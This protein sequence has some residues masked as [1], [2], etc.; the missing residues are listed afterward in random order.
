MKTNLFNRIF[1]AALSLL[2]LFQ[3][4]WLYNAY[5]LNEKEIQRLSNKYLVEA[6]EKETDFRFLE[7][8]KK[9]KEEPSNKEFIFEYENIDHRG[10]ISQQFDITQ[11]LL[12]IKGIP[13]NLF[14]LDSIY[15]SMLS[16]NNIKA[17]YTLIYRD[18]TKVLKAIGKVKDGYKTDR[19]PIVHGTEL[20]AIVDISAPVVFKQMTAVLSLSVLILLLIIACLFYEVRFFFSQQRLNHLRDDFTHALTHDM[21]TPLNSIYMVIDQLGKGVLDNNPTL[22][23][24]FCEVAT[25]QVLNLQNLVDKILTI[26]KM[27]EKK[28]TLSK[29]E[30]NLP[31]M[32][33]SLVDKF[34]VG[35]KKKLFFKTSYDLKERIL[36]ADPVYLSEAISNLIDNAIKYS[37]D[38][39]QIT[40]SCLSTETQIIIKVKDDGTGI[41]F[42]DQQKIFN[43]FERGAAVKKKEVK[44]FGLGLRYVK[45][46]TN[47]HGGTVALSSMEGK[48]SEFVIALPIVIAP[49]DN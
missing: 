37:G 1:I 8:E 24:Q 48:G 34:T 25:E 19:I 21:K 6:I 11:Q 28:L 47:A 41:S 20:Q 35:S 29:K 31:L 9:V 5:K 12:V 44:G 49:I 14:T 33:Q 38:P 26:A 16:Q 7:V 36:L 10:V 17:E 45:D 2:S 30:I 43:K 4:V 39:V 42:K 15:S 22:R 32:I 18:S 46:V 27:E 3:G 13:L 40:I 23:T